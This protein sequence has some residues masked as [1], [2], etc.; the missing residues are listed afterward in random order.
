[1]FD[2]LIKDGRVIDGTGQAGFQASVGI[3]G[4]EV[5]IAR[6]DT[7][8]LAAARVIDGSGYVVCPGFIDMHSH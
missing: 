1:M 7:S 8:S 3:T 5:T 6:G 4:D 2:L